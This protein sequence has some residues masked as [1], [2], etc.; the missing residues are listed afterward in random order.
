MP[1]GGRETEARNQIL[2]IQAL[3]MQYK[4]KF[5]H[6]PPESEGLRALV[7]AGI[8]D[9]ESL[10]EDPWGH[11]VRYL[12]PGVRSGDAFDV[13]SAGHDG[14]EGNDNDI[15]NWEPYTSEAVTKEPELAPSK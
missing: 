12:M 2:T 13:Y 11:S 10:F 6:P 14:I 7:T 3:M 4:V 9:N 15:G 5:H 8:T 1:R